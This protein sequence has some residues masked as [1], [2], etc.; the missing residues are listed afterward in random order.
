MS[1]TS[2]RTPSTTWDVSSMRRAP[3]QSA[4]RP[5]CC[6][7]ASGRPAGR[8]PLPPRLQRLVRGQPVAHNRLAGREDRGMARDDGEEVAAPDAGEL[9]LVAGSHPPRP[10][11]V[12]KRGDLAEPLT[13]PLDSDTLPA[14]PDLRVSVDDDVEVFAG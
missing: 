2:T 12:L 6:T 13:R 10:R 4:A 9:H 11:H 3:S 14:P 8:A 7:T 5:A 1:S